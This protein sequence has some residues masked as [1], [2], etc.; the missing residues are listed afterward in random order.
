MKIGMGSD[1]VFTMFGQNTRELEWFVK[2][3]MTPIQALQSAT[4]IPAEL[5]GVGA[6]LAGGEPGVGAPESGPDHPLAAT[7][8]A[9]SR[10][11]LRAFGGRGPVRHAWPISHP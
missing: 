1:A 11:T 10:L 5:L 2:A 3:G 7:P 9:W 8:R 6:G 4:T